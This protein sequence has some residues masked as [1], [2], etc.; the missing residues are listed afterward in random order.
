[1]PHSAHSH[2]DNK[3]PLLPSWRAW[4]WLVLGA[5]AAEIAVFVWLSRWFAT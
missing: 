2:S 5:L 1:M 3:P 4:Y